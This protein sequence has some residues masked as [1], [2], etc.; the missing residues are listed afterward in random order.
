M[1]PL[2]QSHLGARG[3]R[4]SP[5]GTSLWE[6]R[7]D[8]LGTKPS[9]PLGPSAFLPSALL[10][11]PLPSG[12]R[13]RCAKDP[14]H[15][16]LWVCRKAFFPGAGTPV[17]LSAVDA[18]GH[19]CWGPASVCRPGSV[20]DSP[21]RGSRFVFQPLGPEQHLGSL[22][23]PSRPVRLRGSGLQPSGSACGGGQLPP[24]CLR[25]SGFLSPGVTIAVPLPSWDPDLP[26]AVS[27][28]NAGCP[29]P[30]LLPKIVRGGRIAEG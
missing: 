22:C 11:R 23:R 9:V 10:G 19:S 29:F 16:G 8:L 20:Q 2:P 7:T 18:V 15:S 25:P 6:A 30:L 5:Q 27:P 26:A 13:S 17:A 3:Q 28:C 21:R 24:A 12:P 14:C 1:F 4:Q